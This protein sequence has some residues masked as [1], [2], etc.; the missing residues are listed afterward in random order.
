MNS[1]NTSI[2]TILVCI[3]K[4]GNW[5]SEIDFLIHL[6]RQTLIVHLHLRTVLGQARALQTT[7]PGN[8]AS[9][10][11][12]LHMQI[13]CLVQCY[14]YAQPLTLIIMPIQQ[15]YIAKGSPLSRVN[16]RRA[17]A[18]CTHGLFYVAI[19]LRRIRKQAERRLALFRQF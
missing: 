4:Y 2:F 1:S 12:T 10:L 15:L 14:E 13:R 16:M 5:I 9:P 6:C 17:V 7:L 3:P 18:V 8:R 19:R 11:F